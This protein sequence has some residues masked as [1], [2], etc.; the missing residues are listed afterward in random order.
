MQVLLLT[1]IFFTWQKS[2]TW[3]KYLLMMK[4]VAWQGEYKTSKLPQQLNSLYLQGTALRESPAEFY[5]SFMPF[6]SCRESSSVLVMNE[7]QNLSYLTPTYGGGG[8]NMNSQPIIMLCDWNITPGTFYHLVWGITDSGDLKQP[9]P[10]WKC[11][12]IKFIFRLLFPVVCWAKQ[13]FLV[14]C[15]HSAQ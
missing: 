8:G 7:V 13:L 11:F 2:Q 1:I 10:K 3:T 12:L 14:N 5:I 6:F 9:V 15:Y 4:G